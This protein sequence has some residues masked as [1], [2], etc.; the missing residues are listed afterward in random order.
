MVEQM[1]KKRLRKEQALIGSMQHTIRR[2]TF[3]GRMDAATAILCWGSTKGVCTE[4]GT[5]LGLRVVQ[6]R[7]SFPV[8]GSSR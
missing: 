8:P 6:A 1:A 4:V 5:C 7:C 3:P 2:W